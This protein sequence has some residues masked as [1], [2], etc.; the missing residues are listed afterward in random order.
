MKNPEILDEGA[1]EEALAA[2]GIGELELVKRLGMS[3]GGFN[4]ACITAMPGWRR[5]VELALGLPEGAL[6]VRVE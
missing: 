4:T 3:R 6:A 1:L 2:A 5:R